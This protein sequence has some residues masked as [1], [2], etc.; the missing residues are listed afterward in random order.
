MSKRQ[1]NRRQT[2][3]KNSSR[4][5][6]LKREG[7]AVEVKSTVKAAL[8]QCLKI[9][10]NVAFYFFNFGIFHRFVFN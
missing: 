4:A 10:Q 5:F 7:G 9:T 2:K 1:Q 6:E 3:E 8:A